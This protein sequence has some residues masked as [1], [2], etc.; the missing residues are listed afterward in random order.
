MTTI[1]PTTRL[2]D[3]CGFTAVAVEGDC[4]MRTA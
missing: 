2:I 3:E 4:R 1:D